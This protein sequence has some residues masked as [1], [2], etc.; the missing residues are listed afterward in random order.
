MKSRAAVFTGVG[1]PLTVHEVDIADPTAGE[2]LVRTAACGV[3]HSDLHFM[4]GSLAGPVPTVPGHEPAGVVESVGRGVISVEP[5]DHVIACTSIFCGQCQQCLLGRPHL[6]TD[7]RASRRAKGDPPRISWEG[8]ELK[9][10]ADLSGFSEY[11]LVHERA[12]VKVD[13]DVPLD[14]AALVGCGVTTGVGAALNTARVRPGSSVAVFGAG[15]VGS[16]VIQGARI[17][18][19][20]QIIAVDIVPSKL[21][22]AEHFGATDTI[23]S[24]DAAPDTDPVRAIKKLSSGGVDYAFDA[25][26]TTELAANCLYA[27]APRGT[28]VIVGAIPQG[29]KLELDPGHFYVE[30]TL[31]GSLMGSNRFRIDA[32]EYIDLYRQGKLDLDTMVSER[33]ALDHINEAFAAMAAGEVTRSV[34]VFD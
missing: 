14:R 12:V 6:C 26:G 2:V 25:V 8:R 29:H 5:G 1:D 30:K 13:D 18:G 3:C 23:L 31:T 17:A 15:G 19:A 4:Q 32:L 7:R 33:V 11:M 34:V 21:E 24:G 22:A 10:F 16:A 28:A 27:L 9:Q 20:R